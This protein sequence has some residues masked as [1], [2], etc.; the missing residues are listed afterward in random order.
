MSDHTAENPGGYLDE[1]MLKSFL[2]I[3]AEGDAWSGRTAQKRFL[4]PGT[5]PGAVAEIVDADL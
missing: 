3:T 5:V 2:G 4:R 1:S